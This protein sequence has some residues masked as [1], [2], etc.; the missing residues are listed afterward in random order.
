MGRSSTVV[1]DER[2]RR[3]RRTAPAASSGGSDCL[4]GWQELNRRRASEGSNR[5]L[6]FGLGSF[7][8]ARGRRRPRGRRIAPS[9]SAW[10]YTYPRRHR[11][12]RRAP[13]PSTTHSSTRTLTRARGRPKCPGGDIAD[14]CCPPWRVTSALCGVYR[15]W[16]EDELGVVSYSAAKIC[17]CLADLVQWRVERA[18][19]EA[20]RGHRLFEVLEI[21]RG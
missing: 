16:V 19:A 7:V 11:A 14:G 17:C 2:R 3:R 9:S 6:G 21:L 20:G 8:P 13:P 4:P 12:K 18:Q 5:N 15:R 10:A 1:P